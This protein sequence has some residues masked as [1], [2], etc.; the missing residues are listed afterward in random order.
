MNIFSHLWRILLLLLP[1]IIT[2]V[3]QG[4]GLDETVIFK[5][6]YGNNLFAIV[7]FLFVWL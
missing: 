1:T 4:K 7:C 2:V 6:R 5:L 3:M